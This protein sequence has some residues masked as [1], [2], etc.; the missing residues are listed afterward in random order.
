MTVSQVFEITLLA[1]VDGGALTKQISLGPDG[2]IKSNGSAC[3][4][5]RGTA[6]RA[7]VRN[8][9]ELAEL[10]NS[11]RSSEALALGRLRE[12]LPETVEVMPKRMLDQ[13]NGTFR[14]DL[15]A[16]AGTDIVYRPDAMALALLDV[17]TKG[18][19]ADVAA[20]L[21]ERGGFWGTLESVIPE[22]AGAA[23][24]LR[25]STS[26][27]LYRTD[28]GEKLAGSN[29]IHVFLTVRNG[30]DIERFLKALHA[31][32]WLA[33][34]G[35]TIVGTGGQL[36][37]RSIVDRVVGTPERLVF[38][39]P[40]ILVPPLAQDE[41][42][43]RPIV[44]DGV[45]L[46]TVAACPPLGIVEEQKLKEMRAKEKQR[47]APE[48][49][50]AKE[51]F[52]EQQSQRVAKRIGTDL[53][54]ARKIA[55]RQCSG[56]LLPDLVLP[57]DDPEI[58][59]TTVGDVLA[60]PARFEGETLADP[61]EGTEYGICKARIMRGADGSP[62]IHS[63]AH[64]RTVYD[65]KY[66]ARSIAAALMTASVDGLA[67]RFV[68]FVLAGDLDEDEVERLRDVVSNRTGIGKRALNA[69][70]KRARREHAARLAGEERERRLSDRTDPRPRLAAPLPD[71]ERLPILTAIDDVLAGLQESEPP[72]R[73]AEGCPT[74]VRCRAP[75]MLYA[76]LETENEPNEADP[77]AGPGDAA[78]DAA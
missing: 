31:R 30:A 5:A 75:I 32:C 65:L 16:R 2:T 53:V 73:D 23:R 47:L 17:D 10:I 49:A 66:D 74:E 3:V 56:I 62:W 4:M 38:E 12:D 45:L 29:G 36:L 24:V 33:G 52:I 20:R 40:P 58:T 41:T 34:F 55:E 9:G 51:H 59:G 13:A 14:P 8:V 39:G 15:I 57:F 54:Q 1:K 7:R 43:R 76:L 63:F 18:M 48:I 77:I 25:R 78:F 28:T 27:G 71:A 68:N 22:L 35:W 44:V 61:I 46:D 6:R 21:R 19:P 11:M 64:G 42:S 60:D 72:M 50:K 37:E 69:K 67:E 26:A 70:L